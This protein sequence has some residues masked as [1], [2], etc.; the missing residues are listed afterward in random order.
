MNFR[1]RNFIIFILLLGIEVLI[2]LFIHD[3]FIRPYIGDILVVMVLYF[4]VKSI[5]RKKIKWLTVYVFLFAAL[6][7]IGQ[8]FHIAELL[9]VDTNPFFRVV[10]GATFDWKD[11]FCYMT[12]CILL[13]IFEKMAVYFYN[14]NEEN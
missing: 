11:I 14:S 8:Y 10:L 6:V 5:F 13:F 1:K 9:G 3:T 12:G 2:A 7:E 4:L